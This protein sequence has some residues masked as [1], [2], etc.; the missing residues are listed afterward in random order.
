MRTY[1]FDL[2]LL[3]LKKLLAPVLTTEKLLVYRKDVQALSAS[4]PRVG[5]VDGIPLAIHNL[6]GEDTDLFAEL[7]RQFPE[8]AFATR[9]HASGTQCFVAVTGGVIAGYAWVGRHRLH[10]AEINYHYP[11]AKDE[12]FI[13]D[14]F[15]TPQ[16]R[17]QGIYPTMIGAIMEA[18]RSEKPEMAR[19]LIAVSSMN[20]ASIRGVLKAG[21]IEFRKIAYVNWQGREQWW[22]LEGLQPPAQQGL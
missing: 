5:P 15:V 2:P 11:L 6:S 8:K 17:G 14:C 18:S 3:A 1:R 10:I 19:A 20:K 22:G 12:L 21:F 13:Y 4:A 9:W 7:C 16:H